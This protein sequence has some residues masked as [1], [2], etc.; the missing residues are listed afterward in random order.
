VFWAKAEPHKR[1]RALTVISFFIDLSF[2]DLQIIR[3]AKFRS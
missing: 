3:R 1:V 2:D